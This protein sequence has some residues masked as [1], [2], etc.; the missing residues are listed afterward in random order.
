MHPLAL[1]LA[2][3]L[4]CLPL[5]AQ[6]SD[7]GRLIRQAADASVR[8]D[9]RLSYQLLFKAQQE[10]TEKQEHENLFWVLTNL[11][12]NQAEQHNYSEALSYFTQ[13]QKIAQK[14][15]QKRQQL[16]IRN[17]IAGLYSLNDQNEKALSE[18]L[19]IYASIEK[20][21][22]NRAFCGGCA[23]NIANLYI[24]L[25]DTLRA[26]PFAREAGRSLAGSPADSVAVTAMWVNYL[27]TAKHD[28]AAY[29]LTCR[30]LKQHPQSPELHYLLARTTL[31]LG[32]TAEAKRLIARLLS[33]SPRPETRRD[34]F[35]LM[36]NALEREK[37]WPLALAYKD[38]AEKATRQ[39]F[40]SRSRT[41]YEG[42]QMQYETLQQQQ[43]IDNLNAQRRWS[44]AFIAL[45]LVALA[46]TLWALIMQLRA[47]RR[48]HQLAALQLKQ[49]QEREER[50]QQELLQQQQEAE[51][52]QHQAKQAIERRSRELI[53]K[54]LI[55][56]NRNDQLREL[57]QQ[58]LTADGERR[59]LPSP[60]R[61][62]ITQMLK[63]L[64]STEE[65]RDFSTYF[66][67]VNSSFLHRLHEL[68]PTLTANETRYLSLI[69]INLSTKEISLL[70]NI[71]PEYCKKKKKQIAHKMGLPETRQL[72]AYL[73]NLMGEPPAKE[74]G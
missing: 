58:L 1:I 38:S 33:R 22:G 20:N 7:T 45:C 13:A 26:L 39:T 32:H 61:P 66:E 34:L 12:I 54:A 24:S 28:E 72:Y 29:N 5:Q 10:A 44:I 64:D 46:A 69:S 57:L 9:Y 70:L 16:S 2:L 21:A 47:R 49:Q 43:K 67:Q 65:W 60:L 50:L 36:S 17:N 11:G 37:N 48:Q 8:K 55:T 27:L 59:G 73:A 23:L 63:Q 68:H 42:L 52:E 15:L 30:N 25:G 62:R 41:Q 35:G 40:N 3:L 14:H 4:C 18:Y 19:K 31:S 56:A 53:T 6:R 74:E 71:T 51:A